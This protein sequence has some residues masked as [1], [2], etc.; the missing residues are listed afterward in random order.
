M[1]FYTT[2]K[3]VDMFTISEDTIYH[4]TKKHCS[5]PKNKSIILSHITSQLNYNQKRKKTEN[6]S[7]Y[8]FITVD[9][10]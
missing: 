2:T 3:N 5:V 6:S 7:T 10:F 9:L 4:P 1:K 8:I